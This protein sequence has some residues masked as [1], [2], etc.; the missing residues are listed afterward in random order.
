MTTIRNEYLRR[1]KIEITGY[2]RLLLILKQE[3][4]AR[5]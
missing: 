4:G 3:S 5:R 1:L 2:E